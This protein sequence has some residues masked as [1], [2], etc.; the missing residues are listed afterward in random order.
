M[1][2]HS[3]ILVVERERKKVKSHHEESHFGKNIFLKILIC[4]FV[5]LLV[6][7]LDLGFKLFL[8]LLALLKL[9][10]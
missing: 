7:L 2:N 8:C 3:D 10:G 9:V 6:S 4:L 5:C 1:A